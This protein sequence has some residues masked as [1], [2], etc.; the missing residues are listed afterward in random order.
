MGLWGRPIMEREIKNTKQK[1][2]QKPHRW[3]FVLFLTVFEVVHKKRKPI[4]FTLKKLTLKQ[5][6]HLELL[7]EEP[8]KLT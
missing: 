8:L 5:V 3:W 4:I 6:N 2:I 7:V 1:N